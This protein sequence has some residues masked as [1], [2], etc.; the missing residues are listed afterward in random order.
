LQHAVKSEPIVFVVDDDASMREA[1]VNLI[2]SAG[3]TV[4]SFASPTDF[5]Q[6][7][8]T[9]STACLILDV[10]M[11]GASGLELQHI[12]THSEHRIPI[13]FVSAHGDI[14]MA[15]RAIKEG[16]VEFLP[17]PFRDEDLLHAVRQALERDASTRARRTEVLRIRAL[18][19]RLTVRQCQI[20]DLIVDGR[21]NKQIAAQLGLS[22]NTVK[23]HR[24]RIMEKMGTSSVVR[25]AQMIERLVRLSP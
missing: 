5:L 24:H 20:L 21:L 1:L 13:I 2:G 19:Q 4:E 8:K 25:L 23:V 18:Y 11:P 12:L 17:K 22:E 3:L 15:V 16:A 10:C 9:E 7:S 6:R 14:P